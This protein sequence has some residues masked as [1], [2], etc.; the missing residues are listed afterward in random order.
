MR[1]SLAI[2]LLLMWPVFTLAQEDGDDAGLLTRLIEDALSDVSREVNVVGFRGALRSRATIDVLTIADDEG[3]W[4]RAEDLALDWNRAALFRGALEVRSLSV[5]RISMPRAPVPDSDLDLPTPE[6]T[7]FSLPELPVAIDVD[8]VIAERIELGAPFLGE[9]LALTLSGRAQ[10]ADGAGETEIVAERIDD[11]RGRFEIAGSYSNTSRELALSL[12]LDEAAD[13]I[14]ARLLD[15][16]GRPSVRF[17][18][19]GEGPIDGYTADIR[20]ETE[21]A[22][23]IE[24]EIGLETTI[25]AGVADRRFALDIGGDV[26]ALFLPQYRPFFGEELRL[27][28]FARR[29]PDGTTTLNALDLRAAAVRL[30]GSAALGADGWPERFD[31][32]G[33]I[34]TGDGPVLLPLS[35]DPTEV[36]EVGFQIAFNAALGNRWTGS[37]R[38]R[39]LN[40]PGLALPLLTLTGTGEID[41][42]EGGAVGRFNALLD[43][44]ADGLR[45]NDP[46]MQLAIGEDLQGRIE[47]TRVVG[48]PFSIDEVSFT[49][50]DLSARAIARIEGIGTGLRT[51]ATV[52]AETGNLGRF[53][54]LAGI[55][56]LDGS[57][58]VSLSG[59]F[60]PLNG[61]FDLLLTAGTD[62]L[63]LGIVELDPLLAGTGEVALAV[64]R[65]GTGTR[66]TGLTLRAEEISLTGT[67]DLTSEGAEAA[68]EAALRDVGRVVEGLSG[69]AEISGTVAQDPNGAL[70]ADLAVTAPQ[71]R[72]DASAEAPAAGGPITAAIGAGIGDLAPYA[73]AFGLPLTGTVAADVDIT[74]TP[75][76]GA[77]AVTLDGRTT[78]LGVGVPQVDQVLRGQGQIAA[79]VSGTRDGGVDARDVTIRFP[80]LSANGQFSTGAETTAEFDARLRDVGV[81]T[82]GISGPLDID[83]QSVLAADGTWRVDTDLAGPGGAAV[84][85]RGDIRPGGT[86]DLGVSGSLPLALANGFIDPRRLQ[87]NAAL[88]LRVAGPAALSSVTGTIR[89]ADARLSAPRLGQSLEA[90]GGQITLQGGRALIALRGG[91][92]AG[93]GVEVTGPVTLTA[94]FGADLTAQLQG[95]V[96]RDPQLYETSVNG[97]IRLEGPLAGGA[98]IGGQLALGRTEVQVPSSSVGALGALPTVTHMGAS[99]AVRTTLDRAGLGTAPSVSSAGGGAAFPLDLVI[100]APSRIFIRGRG[101]DAELGGSLRVGGTT[102][103]IIPSGQFQLIR[104]R[105]DIL[106][107]R[108]DLTEGSATL[109]GDFVPFLRLQATTESTSGIL[110]T[111]ILEGPADA[112]EVRFVSSPELPE[113]EVLA[114]LL[115]GR[116]LSEI[117]PLQAV[118]LASAV[119]ELAG[120]G[121]GGVIGQFRDSVG[122]DDLDVTTDETGNAAV[123]AGAY[124]DD[125]LYTSVTVDSEGD[126]K[127][128]LNLDITN[129]ITARGSVTSDGETSIGIF[130]E[131][132]Y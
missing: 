92:P 74:L 68:I 106:Q 87:G 32:R 23:R 8:E 97:T 58:S 46:A 26:T 93:G 29:A 44:A 69:P 120:R 62:D 103:A 83:G 90:L 117:S 54:G 80:N 127:I 34:G 86:L 132:D 19:V 11:A 76:T 85:V 122:L 21:G 66:I 15:L 72:L 4:L 64:E 114:Q 55:A 70:T 7:P 119:A 81:F 1:Y 126:T 17:V 37:A 73:A 105:L 50:D 36:D 12:D 123:R 109:Q 91:F 27:Q 88:D 71:V 110:V 131:R 65:D 82:S 104:G 113:D 100:D 124:L 38:I 53:A 28:A 30:T 40:Q 25:D 128:D 95:V 129:S 47:L 49:A 98:T 14:V 108:F 75:E 84:G 3:I 107:Q 102:S 101:L 116:N 118:Q 125:N 63:T 77:F 35:G 10:L 89:M 57:G 13:G 22:P 59:A 52:L 31:L 18:L 42:G 43:F 56:G 121:N 60:E 130:F 33:S 99:G 20:L 48:E 6:A 112:P 94:P 96:L 78:D 39:N 61:V 111:V 2:L 9:E 24:G 5:A 51:E 45:I 79:D 115:F 41:P 67:A 16:P